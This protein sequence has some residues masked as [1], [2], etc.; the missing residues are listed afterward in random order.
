MFFN[1][2]NLKDQTSET[3]PLDFY[4]KNGS[5]ILSL[6]YPMVIFCD[7]DTKDIIKEMRETE[8]LKINKEDIKTEYIVKNIT[9]YEYFELNW[10]I[11]DENRKRSNGYK[12]VSRNTVSYFLTVMFKAVA[13]RIAKMKNFF[14]TQYYAWIDF[15]CNHI[16]RNIKKYAS[17]ILEQPNPKISVCYI[18]Y[19]GH[20]EI[21][22][23][24]SYM[25]YG[26]K[27]G[28]A[29]TAFTAEKSYIDKFYNLMF[30]IFN[31]QLYKGYGHTE[32]TVMAYCYDRSPELFNIYYGDYYS[33]FS[34]YF[35]PLDDINSIVNFFINESL[36]KNRL[37]LAKNCAQKVLNSITKNELSS[38][39]YLIPNLTKLL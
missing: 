1:L 33:V 38:F 34:N 19:R 2:K 20:E 29:A 18:H 3:R 22:D 5:V 39:Y 26:G 36:R 14:D 8:L 13:L 37:D 12:S 9:D 4:V 25:E 17:R 7:N 35:E 21:R 28:L 23:M 6:P 32:E 11:I 10:D 30:S 27:C 24:K 16:C 15:G 31:E